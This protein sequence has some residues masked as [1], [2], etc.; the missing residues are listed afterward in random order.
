MKATLFCLFL[1][2]VIMAQQGPVSEVNRWKTLAENVTIIRDNWGI[3]H[4]YGKSDA[5]AVFGLMY[6]QCEDDFKRIEMNYVE[7]LG[8]LSEIEGE[9]KLYD[10]LLIRLVIDSAGAIRDYQRSEPWLHKL[11]DAFADGINYYLYTHPE[12]KPALLKHFEPWYALLWTDGSI[13]AINTG[14]LT[15]NDLKDFYSR[16]NNTV[17]KRSGGF[18]I[19]ENGSNGFAVAPSRTASGNSILYI[20]PHVTYYFRP[21]VHMVSEEGLNAYGAVTWGQFFVYQGFNEHCGWMHTSN[22]VDVSDLYLEKIVKKYN[23]FY[24]TYDGELKPVVREKITLNYK[25]SSGLHAKTIMAYFTG[26]GPVMARRSGQWCSMKAIN[27]SMN[28]LVQ[29]WQRTK[30][31]SFAAFKKIMD[32]RENMTNNTVYADAE[33]N[34]AYWH[35]NFVPVRDSSLDWSKPVDGTVASTQWRGLHTVDQIVHVY[36][37][38]SGFLQNCNSTPFTAAGSSSPKREDYRVY[39]APEGE[40]FRGI[41]A[42]QL[43]NNAEGID[44]QK[45][46]ALGY[47]KHMGAF[48]VL[49]PALFK[50]AISDSTAFTGLRE[51]I[52]ILK[53]WNGNSSD[54]SV[55]TSLAI[56]WAEQLSEVM[57]RNMDRYDDAFDQVTFTKAFCD[58]ASAPVLTRAL[59]DAMDELARRYGSWKV[60]WGT[61]NRFQRLT[62]FPDERFD[63]SKPSLPVDRASSQWGTIPGFESKTFTGTNKRYGYGGN[64]FICAVEFGKRVKALSLLTGGESGSPSSPHFT[65]QAAMFVK[66]QFKEVLFY[67]EDVLKHASRTYHPGE[68]GHRMSRP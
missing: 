27:R 6:A 8:R 54:T 39:M 43:L 57:Y 28:G 41:N 38:S 64:S 3:P 35:G 20:N 48:D 19:E 33:K 56:V 58:T 2:I 44:L 13:G 60:T 11:L 49:L 30:A 24:Y 7:K 40:N 42:V 36:N 17:V 12:V 34:I 5:D 37:P 21:E 63:D 26:H 25:D 50:A 23:R 59:S 4:V 51:P 32:L 61:I 9:S 14:G 47:N 45:I 65:D 18:R 46:I 68:K 22:H 66:G 15:S 52:E 62:A 31:T 1:P 53:G 55:A 67:K 16:T 10:D 29:S